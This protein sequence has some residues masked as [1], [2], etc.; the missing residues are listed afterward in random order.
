MSRVAIGNEK[1]AGQASDAAGDCRII[2]HSIGDA[3]ARMIGVL[4]KVLPLSESRL[5]ALLYQAPAEL[6][7]GLAREQ[8]EQINRLLRSTGLDSQVLG[9][10]EAFTAGDASFEV[11]LAIKGTSNMAAIA[12]LIMDV[13][14]VNLEKARAILCASPTVLIG[15]ISA[16]TVEALRRRFAPLGVEIDVSRPASASFD[17]FLGE[18]S[19][20]ERE[21]VKQLLRDLQIIPFSNGEAAQPLLAVGLS[22]GQADKL[23]DQLRRTSLPVRLVNR[24]FERFDLRLDQAPKSTAMIEFL[25]TTTGMPERIAVKVLEKTPVVIQQN[26][27]FAKMAEYLETIAGL[28]GKASGHLLAFQ[29]FSLIVEKVGDATATSSLLQALGGLSQEQ[30]LAAMSPV[31]VMAGTMTNPQVRWLQ[32]ELRRVGTDS[33][34]VLR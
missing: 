27:P 11:A 18:C 13:L 20:P 7:G 33:R 15:H 5:A 32:Q 22:K 16:N 25:V 14:G 12:Q 9:K 30:A 6:I 17:V 31:P 3:G 24:D 23:W 1:Y 21:R 26:I 29:V 4:R 19:V 28:G 2:V 8:A 10:D 34:V